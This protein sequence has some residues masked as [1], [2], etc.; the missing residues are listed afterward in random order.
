MTEFLEA[1]AATGLDGK[2]GKQGIKAE[3]RSQLDVAGGASFTGSVD[4]DEH[5]KGA[6]PTA[7][8]WD[9]GV[10]FMKGGEFALWIEPHPANGTG[11]VA[12]MLRK[13]EWL[14][15]KLR[16]PEFECL[17]ALT[18]AAEAKGEVPFR[19]LYKGKTSFR[20]GG[21]EARLLAQKGMKLP[22]RSIRVG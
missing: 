3:Y 13:L 16:M 17:A 18:A 20:A 5:F 12:V 22:E 9:Y 19:W 14:Q 6:E 15:A 7:N 11:E 8:R 1:V 2:A 21:K 10:G 4:L